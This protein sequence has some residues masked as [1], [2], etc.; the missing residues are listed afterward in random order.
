MK[1]FVLREI[2]EI[3]VN[4]LEKI[5]FDP[6]YRAKA[7]N[8]YR[9]KNIKI[10]P[11]TSAQANIL[12]QTALSCGADCATHR[13]VITGDIE[14]SAVILGG[15]I[16]ELRQIAQKLK[17][18]PFSL[19]V[20]SEKIEGLLEDKPRSSTKIT[21]ILNI[22]PD[23]FSDGGKY[24]DENSACKHLIEMI[25]DGADMIDIGA[26]S[27]RPF[28]QGVSAKEQIKRLTP[29]LNFIE[30]ENFSIPIS[31]DT[32]SSEVA[33][34]VLNKGVQYIND[35]SGFN[36]DS[37]L[38]KVVS[39][40]GA[41][42]ILQHSKGT[43][44]NMQENPVYDDLMGE[45]YTKLQEKIQLAESFG[46][47]NIIIDP[48]I[49][50]GKSKEDNYEILNRIE[51]LYFLGKPVMVGASRKSFLGLEKNTDDMVKDA[52]TLAVSYPLFQKKVD[53]LRVHNVKLHKQLS[54]RVNYIYPYS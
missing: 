34:F 52:L 10:S 37:H 21:G 17:Y 50:F 33:D 45:I 20:L 25:K 18:Q 31:V 5:G 48:G 41:G 22:T 6:S 16:S 9:Y 35:I 23:S 47:K 26:E 29:V 27:T 32:R 53:F 39:K 1:E 38:P 24:L 14:E 28:S 11:L 54:G 36:F 51:E 4:E 2:T 43:P 30:K 44:E 46:I 49:G 13:N 12:K 7:L 40:Y 15:S 19:S 8:K 42:V 3:S